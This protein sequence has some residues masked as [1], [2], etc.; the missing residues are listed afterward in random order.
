MF[1]DPYGT[2]VD[3]KTIKCIA[4]TKAIDL[5]I[6]FPVGTV[7]RLLNRNGKIIESRKRKL[8]KF[9][10]DEKWFDIFFEESQNEKLDFLKD[11]QSF[12]KKTSFEKIVNYYNDK[13]KTVFAGV[14]PNPLI[15]TNSINSPIFVLYFAAGNPKGAETAVRIAENILSK[16]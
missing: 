3:W 2:Q 5:W 12:V 11:E 4:A 13:L 9:F 16:R 7:N 8:N 15:L 14:A 6:L 1:A 10:G